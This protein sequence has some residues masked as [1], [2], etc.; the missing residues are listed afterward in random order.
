MKLSHHLTAISSSIN[1]TSHVISFNQLDH[2]P[3]NF[4]IIGLR[5]R[6]L[7]SDDHGHQRQDRDQHQRTEGYPGHG[8]VFLI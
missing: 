3:C 6:G 8:V 4:L 1:G 7:G 5:A 2:F